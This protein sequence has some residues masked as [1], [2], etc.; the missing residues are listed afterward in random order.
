V[1]LFVSHVFVQIGF[2]F[3]HLQNLL[4]GVKVGKLDEIGDAVNLVDEEVHFLAKHGNFEKFKG[5]THEEVAFKV[6]GYMQ[7]N[8]IF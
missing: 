3:E 1:H 7:I 5:W 8:V 2:G 4:F 6:I